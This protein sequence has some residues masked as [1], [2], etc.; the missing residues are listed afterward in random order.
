[1]RRLAIIIGFM[2]ENWLLMVLWAAANDGTGVHNA[3]C[4]NKYT[5]TA[6]VL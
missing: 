4:I 3:L 1:L 5:H 2:I 6:V